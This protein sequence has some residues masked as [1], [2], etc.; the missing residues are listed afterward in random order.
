MSDPTP[1]KSEPTS[2]EH[3]RYAE[4]APLVTRSSLVRDLQ[5]LGLRPGMTVIAHS[6]IRAIAGGGYIVGGVQTVLDALLEVL[7]P[8]GTLVMPTHSVQYTDPAG[9]TRP[10]V[11]PAWVPTMRAEMPAFDP[12]RS[13]STVGALPEYFRTCPGVLRSGHPIGSC[14]AWGRHAAQV[15]DGDRFASDLGPESPIGQVYALDGWVLML[16]TR[17]HNNTSLHLAEHYATWEGKAP[18]VHQCPVLVDGQRVMRHIRAESVNSADF[19]AAGAAFEAA[20]PEHWTSRTVGAAYT[21]LVRQRPLV[22]YAIG[23]MEANRPASLKN[24]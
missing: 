19:D 4:D 17:H 1:P 20:S 6:S 24:A 22:D 15:T 2:P 5:A 14:A 18:D 13:P 21:R 23:W 12:Q 10:P 16:G 8:E 7:T 3:T 11:P 9:W